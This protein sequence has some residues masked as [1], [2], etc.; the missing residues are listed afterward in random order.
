MIKNILQSQYLRKKL[1]IP[2]LLLLLFQRLYR[3]FRAVL[4]SGSVSRRLHPLL[5][6]FSLYSVIRGFIREQASV[7]LYTHI[8]YVVCD[9]VILHLDAGF[10][11][12]VCGIPHPSTRSPALTQTFSEALKAEHQKDV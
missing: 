8:D 9:K 10:D 2:I 4:P 3:P 7:L 1:I 5:F 6:F 12:R 11:W